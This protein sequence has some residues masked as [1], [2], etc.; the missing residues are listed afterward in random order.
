[1]V[2]VVHCC[3]GFSGES[4]MG[5]YPDKALA[6]LRGVSTRMESWV[7]DAKFGSIVLPQVMREWRD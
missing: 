3:C 4:A 1:M 6:V 2:V 7:Q 5:A